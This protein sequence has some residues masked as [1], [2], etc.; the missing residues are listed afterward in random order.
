MA[1]LTAMP[2]T[3][4]VIVSGPTKTSVRT[5]AGLQVDLRVVQPDVWGAALQYFTGSQHHNVAIRE[6]A[7]R[8]KLKLSE[9][10]LF[11]AVSGELIV[12]QT[13][14]EVYQR[15]GLAYIPPVLRED[16]GEVQAARRGDLPVLVSPADVRGDLHSHTSLTDGAATLEEMVTKAQSLG[17]E[18][19]A[20][21][22]HAPDL[23]MQ[24]MTDEKMLAQ[25]E[26]V[27]RLG[28]QLAA[29]PAAR[30]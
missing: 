21:T 5:R 10:G 19:F 25:R 1:A 17:Y 18:Y 28:E 22:D 7:V 8:R 14:E 13:E 6:L 15:L 20:I 3:A 30:R 4:D 29:G 2:E 12:A 26:Q 11:D 16:H 23:V 9:Y 27:R 24:R